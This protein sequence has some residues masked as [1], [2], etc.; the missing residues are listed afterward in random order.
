ML[1][2]LHVHAGPGA[3]DPE[4]V[5][6]RAPALG[7]EGV[8]LVGD[9]ALPDVSSLRGRAVKVFA[10]I[11]ATTDRGHYLVFL[12]EPHRL[13][14]LTELFGPREAGPWA[15]RDVLARAKA[16]G[17]AV[18]A[19]HPYDPTVPH[20]GG[21]IVYTLP[22]LAAVETVNPRRAPGIQYAAVEAA[23]TLGLPAVGGSDARHSLEELGTAATLF[24]EPIEDEAGLVAALRSGHC[25]PVEFGEPGADLLRRGGGRPGSFP[26]RSEGAGGG[27]RR[28]RR[29]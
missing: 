14:P 5:L 24:A 19:A 4:A 2:D 29:R 1:V 12:P 18:V 20:P 27:G 10:G 7:L 3:L 13:P 11:E 21:D 8:A 25:W 22:T 6:A 17:G 26:P 15:V 9:D 23:E 16:L 28:R